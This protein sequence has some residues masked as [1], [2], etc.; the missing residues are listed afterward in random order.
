MV[1][2]GFGFF[3]LKKDIKKEVNYVV[4]KKKS[5]PAKD[6]GTYK[7]KPKFAVILIS[8]LKKTVKV[9]LLVAKPLQQLRNN[10]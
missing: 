8:F 4:Q 3:R 2:P 5:L 9:V 10:D 7:L 1:M 6:L